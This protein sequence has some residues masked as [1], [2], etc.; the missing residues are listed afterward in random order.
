MTTNK[1]A[2]KVS[3]VCKAGQ[4]FLSVQTN[5]VRGVTLNIAVCNPFPTG[6]EKRKA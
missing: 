6:F 1:M 4:R 2:I 3:L 5:K